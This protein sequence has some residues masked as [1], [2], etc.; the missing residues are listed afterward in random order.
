[1]R[2]VAVRHPF[3][4]LARRLFGSEA[5]AKQPGGKIPSVP[6]FA[7]PARENKLGTRRCCREA[8]L[9][10]DGILV[11]FALPGRSTAARS[12]FIQA[13]KHRKCPVLGL[14]NPSWLFLLSHRNLFH[15]LLPGEKATRGCVQ[16]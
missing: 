5:F 3:K 1:M 13:T 6:L 15:S 16:V 14:R 9:A 11:R 12:F 8:R 2:V 7:T 10:E 4:N